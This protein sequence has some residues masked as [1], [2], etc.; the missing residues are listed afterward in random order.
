MNNG[1]RPIF[2]T[3]PVVAWSQEEKATINASSLIV[4]DAMRRLGYHSITLKRWHP[5][6]RAMIV[7]SGLPVIPLFDIDS[8]FIS[9]NCWHPCLSI[10]QIV[11]EWARKMSTRWCVGVGEDCCVC[12][13]KIEVAARQIYSRFSPRPKLVSI[14][15][16]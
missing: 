8:R 6:S 3:I 5:D 15:L 2:V 4:A 10:A 13:D 7:R 14:P 9:V 16:R 1:L 11:P 12:G